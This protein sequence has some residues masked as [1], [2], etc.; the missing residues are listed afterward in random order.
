MKKSNK[1]L[2]TYKKWDSVNEGLQNINITFDNEKLPTADRS[3]YPL[4][5][6]HNW[7]YKNIVSLPLLNDNECDLLVSK[8]QDHED[9]GS[10]SQEYTYRQC[11][12][13]W[14]PYY[15][16]GFEFL[17][18]KILN[19]IKKVNDEVYKFDISNPVTCESIQFTKYNKGDHYKTHMDW[20]GG[21]L[22]DTRKI[23]F[24]INLT[25]PDDYR[26][27]SLEVND[28]IAPRTRGWIHIFPSFLH[29]QAHTVMKGTRFSFLG[30]IAGPPFK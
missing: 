13:I 8:W 30:C 15:S 29:H 5:F 25:S 6:K 2:I 17:F 10:I 23:S 14:I 1:N 3:L 27:G 22:L 4:T 21:G 20:D 19:T 24:S 26:G 28:E 12:I 18:D 11:D 9:M 7:D 16:K